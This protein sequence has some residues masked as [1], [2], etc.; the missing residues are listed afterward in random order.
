MKIGSES[1]R[2]DIVWLEGFLQDTFVMVFYG[3][4]KRQPGSMGKP[5]IYS[6]VGGPLNLLKVRD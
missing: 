1:R 4:K 2:I 5:K 6:F 3:G